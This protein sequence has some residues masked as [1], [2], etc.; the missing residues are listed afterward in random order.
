MT[1]IGFILFNYVR[2]LGRRLLGF[3][4]GL[5]GNGMAFSSDA[6]RANPWEAYSRAE[7]LEFGIILLLRGV[8]IRFAPEAMV[9]AVMPEH[10]KNAETQRLRW[11]GGRLPVVRRY[12]G[13]LLARTIS[14]GSL[15][16]LDALI[17]LVTPPLV[18]TLA[19]LV[20]C[21][22]LHL[23][24][25]AAGWESDIRFALLWFAVAGLGIAH[26]VL[27]LIAFRADR[28]TYGALLHIPRYAVWKLVLLGKQLFRPRTRDW[29]RT[30]RE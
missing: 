28:E 21:G 16:S 18:T 24:A 14:R 25:W 10:S 13:P 2:P 27:G 20:G 8:N 29:I 23:L 22:G 12:A 6:L 19:V 26:M 1:R 17:D 4:A 9:T 11:E 5:R 30:T 7:D 15:S 3:S